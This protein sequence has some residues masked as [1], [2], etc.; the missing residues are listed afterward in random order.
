[1][2]AII[3]THTHLCD[4]PDIAEVLTASAA[5][6]V[7]DIVA[8]GIDLASNKRHIE[9]VQRWQEN[10]PSL[11]GEVLGMGIR[12]HLALGLHPGNVTQQEIDSCISFFRDAL[13]NLAGS[14]NEGLVVAIGEIGLDFWYKTVRQD[15]IKKNEQRAAFAQQLELAREF[16]L[17]V[18][19]HSR[20]TWRECLD[21]TVKAGVRK[22]VFHWYSGPVDVLKDILDAGFLMSVSPAL[23]YGVEVRAAAAY[24]PIDRILVETD[25]PVIYSRLHSGQ[26][27]P[28]TPEDVWLSF[29]S[30]CALKGLD[31]AKTLDVVNASARA[32]FDL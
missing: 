18:V 11:A 25:T 24:A 1:M 31:E 12:I 21:M 23:A 6:G 22:A 17:P 16:D 20:G 28:S 13:R 5:S 10:V 7:S 29:R 19:I 4:I 32:F 2:P 15:D 3:D 8:L 26:S 9:I 14:A 27:V 30:L